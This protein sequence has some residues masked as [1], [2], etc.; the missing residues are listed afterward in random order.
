MA[1]LYTDATPHAVK[2]AKGLHLLTFSTPNGKKV[3]IYLEELKDAYRTEWTASLIDIDTDEQKQD[4]F[5]RLNP[6]D[7]LE[8]RGS[9]FKAN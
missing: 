6:N 5:L 8:H 2:D 3:Q 9:R 1:S 7:A 4:L